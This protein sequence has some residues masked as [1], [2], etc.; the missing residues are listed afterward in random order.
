[1][2][3][4][5]E[6]FNISTE[7][8]SILLSSEEIVSIVGDKIYPL[9]APDG[10]D[11]DFILYQ[12]EKYIIERSKMGKAGQS[13][14]VYVE[15]VSEKYGRSKDLA[16]L[17]FEALDGEFTDPD[18]TIHLIDATEDYSDGKF[19]QVLLFSIQ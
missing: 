18:M 4:A 5:E 12:R 6:K 15:T 1:M 2:G 9:V 16:L 7:I 19:I 13:C 17:V 14:E 8:R 11:G 3:R 10:T